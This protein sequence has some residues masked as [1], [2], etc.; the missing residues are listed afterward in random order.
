[1]TSRVGR[2]DDLCAAVWN[3][4]TSEASMM[5]R[6]AAILNQEVVVDIDEEADE[7]ELVTHRSGGPTLRSRGE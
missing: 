7:S 1:M 4:P 2:A 3:A 5:R 6:I